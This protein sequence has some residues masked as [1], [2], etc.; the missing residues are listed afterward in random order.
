MPGLDFDGLEEHELVLVFRRSCEL[1][2]PAQTQ[3]EQV[4]NHAVELEDEGCELKAHDNTI[5]VGMIHVFEIDAD[6]VFGGHV[7]SDVMVDDKP[8]ETIQKSEIDLLI[9]FIETGLEQDKR[10]T[11][12]GIPST[13]QV[14]DA[15]TVLVEQEWWG[16]V[17]GRLDP[18]GE[19]SPFV[20]LVPQ[21]LIKV[22]IGD[23]L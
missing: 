5:K 20:S 13:M 10:L 19:E 14:I 8:E 6:I 22:G 21:V 7:I 1:W 9:D 17:V 12:T 15:L 2:C 4:D 11:L 3:D 23:F 16:F 18:V